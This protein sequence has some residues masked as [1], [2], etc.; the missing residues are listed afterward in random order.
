MQNAEVNTVPGLCLSPEEADPFGIMWL[1]GLPDGNLPFFLPRATEDVPVLCGAQRLHCIGMADQLLLHTLPLSTDHID[2]PFALA[3]QLPTAAN[4]QLE[5]Q[6]K[7]TF[8]LFHIS[9]QNTVKEV[10]VAHWYSESSLLLGWKRE[11][12]KIS[13]S[14]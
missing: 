3:L 1:S 12:L 5:E 10:Y 8:S 4:P 14:V 7:P 9:V 11:T 13:S 2:L 6:N